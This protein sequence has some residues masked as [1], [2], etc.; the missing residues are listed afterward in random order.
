MFIPESPV[1]KITHLI[2]KNGSKSGIFN[3]FTRSAVFNSGRAAL[4][5]G[6]K[7][8]DISR[9]W[10]PAYICQSVLA[11]FNNLGIEVQF[12]DVDERLRPVLDILPR[13][14]DALLLVHFFGMCQE[15]REIK[16]YCREKGIYLIE[17]CAHIIPD[18]YGDTI[19]GTYGDIAFFSF[20]KQLPVPDGGMLVI[21]N[22]GISFINQNSNI[23]HFPIKKMVIQAAEKVAFIT[24]I[25]IYPYKDRL[26]GVVGS[27]NSVFMAGEDRVDNGISPVTTRILSNIDIRRSINNKRKSFLDL[28]QL[29]KGKGPIKPFGDITPGSVPQ[30]YPVLIE[31]NRDIICKSL[32]LHGIGASHWPGDEYVRGIDFNK[33]PGA[34]MWMEKNLLLPVN[35]SLGIKHLRDIS[36]RVVRLTY[37]GKE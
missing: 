15:A 29:L 30:L 3:V 17:D 35:E 37:T 5:Y 34:K 1:L 2:K 14:K 7:C 32:R 19:A 33:F 4:S 18:V 9:V 16:Q 13:E 21:N 36:S 8:L 28:G 27:T 24:G 11:P 25:N 20:R 22:P 10:V 31:D 12:Y 23:G 6:L 26:R